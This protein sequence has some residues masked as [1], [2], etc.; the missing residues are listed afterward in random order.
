MLTSFL[1][2]SNQAILEKKM[3]KENQISHNTITEDEYDVEKRKIRLAFSS[4][5]VVWEGRHE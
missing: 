3:D 5:H 2:Q 4:N 1:H